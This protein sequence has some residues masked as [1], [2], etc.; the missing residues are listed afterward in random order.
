MTQQN[1]SAGQPAQDPTPQA[2]PQAPASNETE[3]GHH[4]AMI[5]MMIVVIVIAGM[6]GYN[7]VSGDR[8]VS[9]AMDDGKVQS[10]IEAGITA[11]L[12][13]ARSE[14]TA[15]TPVAADDDSSGAR[16]LRDAYGRLVGYQ[17]IDARQD[18]LV[19]TQEAYEPQLGVRMADR[20][21]MTADIPATPST[22][23][24]PPPADPVDEEKEALRA[25]V[26][27][28]QELVAFKEEVLRG[29]EEERNAMLTMLRKVSATLAA[30]PEA[31]AEIDVLIERVEEGCR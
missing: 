8:N 5:G 31:K 29:S 2:A 25:T 20:V 10:A 24:F 30:A 12:A 4:W 23:G 3:K 11:G 22:S 17:N 15:E 14:R 7:I 13:K 18:H 21:V 1:P 16:A 26:A 9:V 6:M 19:M 27:G 28:L